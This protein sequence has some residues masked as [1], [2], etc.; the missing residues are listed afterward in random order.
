V[1]SRGDEAA[2]IELLDHE[3]EVEVVSAQAIEF[4]GIYRGHA[5]FRRMMAAFWNPL[6]AP[7]SRSRGACLPARRW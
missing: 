7:A 1:W 5:G 3:V 6:R 2:A 4:P